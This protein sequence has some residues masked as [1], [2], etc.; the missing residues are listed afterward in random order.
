LLDDVNSGPPMLVLLLPVLT[1][2]LALLCLALAFRAGRKRRLIDDLPTLKSSG[3]F[4]GLA[5]LMID[6]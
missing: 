4:I 2:T 6:Q 3:V 1:G 5:E